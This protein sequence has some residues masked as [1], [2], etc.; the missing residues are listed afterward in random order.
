MDKAY[1]GIIGMWLTGFIGIY[2][3]ANIPKKIEHKPTPSVNQ[4]PPYTNMIIWA[5]DSINGQ[6]WMTCIKSGDTCKPSIIEGWGEI[7]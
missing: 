1:Y 7:L 5:T 6:N 4:L 2:I 3:G